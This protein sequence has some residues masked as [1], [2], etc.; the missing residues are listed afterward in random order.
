MKAFRGLQNVRFLCSPS[1]DQLPSGIRDFDFVMLSAVYEHLLPVERK[2]LMPLLWSSMKADGVMFINQT[3]YRYSPCEAHSTGLW[4]IN[5]M[6]DAMTHWTVRHFAGRNPANRSKDWNVHLRGGIRGA[7]EREIIGN[8]TGGD[9]RSARILQPRQNALR[10]RADLWLSATNPRRYGTLKKY[11]A[12]FFR[13]TDRAFG[14][15][16]GINLEVVIQKYNS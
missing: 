13:L 7:T 15:I 12:R 14:T 1:G 6:P 3:P 9:M 4:F 5:Y 16:P 8:L 2:M 10:D 11:I